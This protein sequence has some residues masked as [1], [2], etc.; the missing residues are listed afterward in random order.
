[1]DFDELLC[2]I[3][4]LFGLELSSIRPGSNIMV[5]SINKEDG[6]ILIKAKGGQIK[7]RPIAEIKKIWENLC[8]YPVVRVENALQGAGSSRNHP[9][10]IFANLPYIE[11][12]LID[13]KKHICLVDN[14]THA[15]GTLRKMEDVQAE[16]VKENLR[17]K[18]A[19][20]NSIAQ[21][22]IVSNDISESA[23]NIQ[24]L[25]GKNFLPVEK[26]IYHLT[27]DKIEIYLVTPQVINLSPGSYSVLLCKNHSKVN[28]PIEF[29]GQK[30]YQFSDSVGLNLLIK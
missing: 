17:T 19:D 13:G 20:I 2:D 15:Y 27:V 5:E 29:L 14:K 11:W 30:Y 3:E 16:L 8:V 22:I 18:N 6:R 26:G 7:S 1:M 23:E 12:L 4:K 28:H 24:N 9:E 10:T 21:I 25:T